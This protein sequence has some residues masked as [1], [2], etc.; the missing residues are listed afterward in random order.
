MGKC[1]AIPYGFTK[2]A[3]G[4]VRM[5]ASEIEVVHRKYINDIFTVLAWE[6]LLPSLKLIKLLFPPVMLSGHA[7]L[8]IKF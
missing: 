5:V 3:D 2:M 1:M 4:N 7:P 6:A 8:L